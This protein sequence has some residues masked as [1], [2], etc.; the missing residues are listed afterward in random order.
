MTVAIRQGRPIQRLSLADALPQMLRWNAGLAVALL[1]I[2]VLVTRITWVQPFIMVCDLAALLAVLLGVAQMFTRTMPRSPLFVA[3]LIFIGGQLVSYVVHPDLL[4]MIR[5]LRTFGILVIAETLA[6]LAPELRAKFEKG[7]VAVGV[8]EV[9]LTVAHRILGRAIAPG[10]IEFGSNVVAREN[11][12]ISV[13][14]LQHQYVLAGLGLLV[15]AVSVL[16][17]IRSTL[18][19]L[20]AFAGIGTCAYLAVQS[21]G[22]AAFLGVAALAFSLIVGLFARPT[23]RKNLLLGVLVI[24]AGSAIGYGITR[25]GWETRSTSATITKDAGRP[26]MY[27]QAFG[28]WK[29]SPVVGV[30]TGR[31]NVALLG[32]PT[33]IKLTNEFLPVH[34]VPLHLAAETGIL[35]LGTVLGFALL[36]WKRLRSLGL[37]VVM[38]AAAIAP[39]I[40]FDV[41][42]WV[43][44]TGILQLGVFVGMLTYRESGLGTNLEESQAR[45]K[46]VAA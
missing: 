26:A 21:V 34:N 45:A 37:L 8:F 6:S 22:R 7:I 29:S 11:A 16:G 41:F 40:I 46:A 32:E 20:W 36:L 27:K 39:F 5:I 10:V 9:L 30:G 33:L 4:G 25:N 38:P 43:I 31:Y 35:G 44:P 13:G 23:I 24:A 28:L 14:S 1:P 18:P 19:P 17:L 12:A 2:G 15:G 42:H 3:G